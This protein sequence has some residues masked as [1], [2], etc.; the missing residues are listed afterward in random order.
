MCELKR[1]GVAVERYWNDMGPAWARQGMCELAL[2]VL[3]I[4]R[5][6]S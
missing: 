6:I 1:H 2:K 3:Q 5:R 4:M